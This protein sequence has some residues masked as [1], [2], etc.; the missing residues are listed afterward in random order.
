MPFAT[1][2]TR[3]PRAP[4]HRY[5]E[6]SQA[7][8]TTSPA[9]SSSGP[10]ADPRLAE[11]APQAGDLAHLRAGVEDLERHRAARG[12]LGLVTGSG[13][14]TGSA[15]IVRTRRSRSA[16]APR[17]RR[18][19]RRRRGGCEPA[20]SQPA[21]RRAACRAGRRRP[22]RLRVDVCDAS[23]AAQDRA[24]AD[25]A[26]LELHGA[27]VNRAAALLA[28]RLL[29]LGDHLLGEVARGPPRSAGTPSCS[30]RARR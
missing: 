12:R 24:A 19:R 21:P 3:R 7:T 20:G 6:R 13:S 14:G 16:V 4:L 15:T 17:R 27:Q 5:Q 11:R 1:C 18:R 30:R 22:P 8:T 23:L 2:F 28:R 9:P 29:R 26:G 25:R 10:H